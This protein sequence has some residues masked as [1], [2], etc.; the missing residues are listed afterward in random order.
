MRSITSAS[1]VALLLVVL[2]TIIPQTHAQF[3][4][5]RDKGKI[6]ELLLKHQAQVHAEVSAEISANGE[7]DVPAFLSPQDAADMEE[8]ILKASEDEQT[9]ELIAKMKVDMRTEIDALGQEPSEDILKGM[10]MALDE[11]KMLDYLF[12]DPE[13]AVRE[14]E[15]DGLI[16]DDKKKLKEYKMD[17]SLLETDTRKGLYFSFISLAVAGGYL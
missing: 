10:K 11:M 5:A 2:S 3:G 1:I 17:P 12:K 13:R 14:M 15:K 16:G 4:V 6:K 8:L 7:A 9:I